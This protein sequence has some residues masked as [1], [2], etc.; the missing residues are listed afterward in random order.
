MLIW[1][2]I[3]QTLQSQTTLTS[4]FFGNLARQAK[5]SSYNLITYGLSFLATLLD[6]QSCFL[7]TLS[8]SLSFM[9]TL[10]ALI[11]NVL[12]VKKFIFHT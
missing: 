11:T 4:Q 8:Y 3:P 5:L 9:T 6:K 2:I 10:P 7:T 1:R 12:F